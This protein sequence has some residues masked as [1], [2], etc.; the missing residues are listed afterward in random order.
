MSE[1]QLLKPAG[2]VQ[3]PAFS[4]VAIVP[5][6]ATTVYV[7]GQ[8]AVDEQGQ[9]VGGDDAAAQTTKT[10]ENVVTA[11]AAAGLGVELATM[12]AA[13]A[14]VD[15]TASAAGC[16]PGSAPI[17]ASRTAT[18]RTTAA[19]PRRGGASAR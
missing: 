18:R 19:A 12:V 1:I 13:A 9:L 4:H 17:R 8:N 10:M 3:S 2:L 14:A 7:G 5:P 16:S 11:L 15:R 6:G